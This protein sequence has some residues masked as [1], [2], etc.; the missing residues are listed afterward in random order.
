[1]PT[2]YDQIRSSNSQYI[3]KFVG[4]NYD[5][6]NKAASTLDERYR[7]NKAYSD[8][9]AM[10]MAQEQYLEGDK[11]I[12]EN[13]AKSIY[14]SID[15]ISQGDNFENSTAA[16]SQLAR[17][18]FTNQDRLAALD[19]YKRVEEAKKLQTTLGGDALNF[20]EDPRTFRTLDP[21]TGERRIYDNRIEKRMDYSKRMQELLGK[22][23]DDGYTT[24]PTGEKIIFD[25]TERNLIKSGKVN[26]LTESKLNRLVEGLL[27]SYKTTGEGQQDI[28]R[29]TQ[30]AGYK[31]E[32]ITLSSKG[33]TRQT[34]DVDEDIRQRFRAIAAPQAYSDTNMKWDDF[35]LT[36]AELE[37]QAQAQGYYTPTIPGGPTENSSLQILPDAES[38]Y[39]PDYTINGQ[40]GKFFQ[41]IDLRTG[42]PAKLANVPKAE[43][44][45]GVGAV[46]NPTY[47]RDIA[48]YEVREI[49]PVRIEAALNQNF[50]DLTG[51]FP[52]IANY[53]GNYEGFKKSYSAAT[54]THAKITPVG[55]QIA[56]EQAKTYDEAVNRSAAV[57]PI[58]SKGSDKAR[59]LEELASDI[60]VAPQD[61]EFKTISTY[62][63]S[64]SKEIP[65]GYVEAR[66]EIKDTK[67][68]K[69]KAPS[70]VFIPLNDQ[71]TAAAK[72][73]D[74]VFKNSL[75]QGR[76][77]YSRNNP[78]KTGLKGSDG[79]E[80]YVYTVT[81]PKKI[82]DQKEGKINFDTFVI[83]GE[84]IPNATG[85]T[86]V[87]WNQTPIK[88][89]DWRNTMINRQTALLQNALNSG[90]T[91][92]SKDVKDRG[93]EF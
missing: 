42:Q 37:K 12:K 84:G 87:Q 8:K 45:G 48:N 79:S 41:Y 47:E 66:V 63:D 20:G 93:L 68:D 86:T 14:G 53:Y 13:L 18:F 46:P 69:S 44:I 70:T 75:Y 11:D 43:I 6:L 58:Y 54:K 2:V 65:G 23:A 76:D 7:S 26:Q 74:D 82:E 34:T 3:P 27:Y 92:S 72:P 78:Y 32:P 24:G 16:V 35:G 5:E 56:P 19:N 22:V 49:D 88:I 90:Q 40:N 77:T 17:D 4:S 1:M 33:I 55:N 57:S 30:L 60:G 51:E 71:F 38:A 59:S 36:K 85:G 25:N 73:I 62:Y 50:A 81:Y 39:D 91:F 67:A 31:N 52:A 64:P 89:G 29:L 10:M 9:I 28:K 15:K 80:L 83:E 61:V 21:T